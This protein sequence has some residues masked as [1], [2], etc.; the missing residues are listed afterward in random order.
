MAKFGQSASGRFKWAVLR[1]GKPVRA[2][3]G[4][5]SNLILNR[6]LQEV[7]SR[8]WAAC[9]SA[10]L[11]GSD[12]SS[13][14]DDSGTTTATSDA[15]GNVTLVGG[16]FTLSNPGDVGNI[17]QWDTGEEGRITAVS[18][19]TTCTITPAPGSIIAAGEFTLYH[20]NRTGMVSE[21]K[22]TSTYVTGF[23]FCQSSRSGDTIIMRRTYLFSAEVGAV[24][25]EE[26]GVGWSTT[27]FAANTT[28]ARFLPEVGI[29]VAIGEQLQVTY[30]LQVRLWPTLPQSA[31]ATIADWPV[32]PSTNTDGEYQLQLVGIFSVNT[33]GASVEFDVGGSSNEPSVQGGEQIWMQTGSA[34]L[35]PFADVPTTRGSTAFSDLTLGPVNGDQDF[36]GL[37]YFQTKSGTYATNAANGTLFRAIGISSSAGNEDATTRAGFVFLFDQAQTKS[38]L[39]TLTLV[40]EYTWSR[41][42]TRNLL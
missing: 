41:T 16:A 13:S 36:T 25:Y 19:G 38:T 5:R 42:L 12:G 35:T 28:F 31:T 23:G 4:W 9:F 20:A 33:S 3:T 8:T 10:C 32:A 22:R 6:G 7:G 29:P 18:S 30:E 15:A 14:W 27:P 2:S 34:A 40:F 11:G 37:V 24:T 17:I 26:L 21:L 1:D 39:Y